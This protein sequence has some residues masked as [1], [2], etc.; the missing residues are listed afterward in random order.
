MRTEHVL[1][2]LSN[3]SST[4][5]QLNGTDNLPVHVID[6][7]PEYYRGSA[8]GTAHYA[9]TGNSGPQAGDVLFVQPPHLTAATSST[10]PTPAGQPEQPD[11]S[12]L[13]TEAELSIT[14]GATPRHIEDSSSSMRSSIR[15]GDVSFD[16]S[17]LQ[18]AGP[19]MLPPMIPL[20]PNVLFSA[21][22]TAAGTWRGVLWTPQPDATIRHPPRSRNEPSIVA[23]KTMSTPWRTGPTLS[24]GV[25]LTLWP[26]GEWIGVTRFELSFARTPRFW[27]VHVDSAPSSFSTGELPLQGGSQFLLEW[28]GTKREWVRRPRFDGDIQR[29]GGYAIIPPLQPP[30]PPLPPERF[31]HPSSSRTKGEDSSVAAASS[32][33][34]RRG[35]APQVMPMARS[36][37]KPR[38]PVPPQAE[39]HSGSESET[40]WPS[41]DPEPQR[42]PDEEEQH[43]TSTSTRTTTTSA[44]DLDD[45]PEHHADS[46]S[47]MQNMKPPGGTGRGRHPPTDNPSA[48]SPRD[49]RAWIPESAPQTP[50][51]I[52][53][54]LTKVVHD[55]LQAS[56][57]QPNEEVTILAYRACGYLT[58]LQ[59]ASQAA[60][61]GNGPDTVP[62]TATTFA[63][64]NPLIE[65]EA[66]L[67]NLY[68]NHN[69][70][71]KR[72]LYSEIARVEQLLKD[73][74]QVFTS[75]ARD[76]EALG[77]HE[78]IAGIR[79]ALDAMDWA[80]L[81]V[82]EGGIAQIGETLLIASEA[83]Q[84][85]KAYMDTLMVWLRARFEDNPGSPVKRQRTSERASGSQHIPVY[86]TPQPLLPPQV[87]AR[88]DEPAPLQRR[89][90]APP[91]Q[92]SELPESNVP[93]H[94]Q[95]Q[96]RLPESSQAGEATP[97]AVL[98]AQ[99]LLKKAL[100]FLEQELATIVSEAYANLETWTSAI[101]GQPIQ[102]VDT[103]EEV[104]GEPSPT[105]LETC[106]ADDGINGGITPL[107]QADTVL[108][109]HEDNGVNPIPMRRHRERQ[110]SHRHRR[111]Q[112]ALADSSDASSESD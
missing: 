108:V 11:I 96:R 13:E 37:P 26:V 67:H 23:Y 71:P 58:Q 41:E 3:S 5:L 16:I 21:R 31:G 107:S 8:S 51:E 40:S 64:D 66:T 6:N 93:R 81:A 95:Q 30:E 61:A 84:R 25:T 52:L 82:E 33:T 105:Q 45:N 74:K 79:N 109:Q 68:Q 59:S 87:R 57:S 78:G 15:V 4:Q 65:A 80:H 29:L 94:L 77:A 39:A 89:P 28:Q 12:D 43:T 86:E 50:T 69:D 14:Q 10:G 90:R 112:A 24:P 72:H 36:V 88:P 20:A 34:P 18:G 47:L 63:F 35:Q 110:P 100:P 62:P 1:R 101:W 22:G 53:Q 54:A 92:D 44:Q 49:D 85:S 75:W 55:L 98:K 99:E 111:L 48:A 27:L 60:P 32:S 73:A 19:P 83:T 106:L 70:L 38:P 91:L 46:S 9:A 7:R 97:Y 104:A 76:P 2:R 103:Q 102:L 42:A 56:F 17:W